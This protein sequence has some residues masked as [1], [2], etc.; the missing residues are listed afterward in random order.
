MNYRILNWVVASSPP[1]VAEEVK[2]SCRQSSGVDP[3]AAV[4]S[5]YQRIGPDFDRQRSTPWAFVVE[6][7]EE[8]A[9]KDAASADLLVAGCGHGRHV[10]VAMKLGYEVTGID[11]NQRM[12]SAAEQ[13]CLYVSGPTPRLL[14]A[15]VCD[16]PFQD[17]SFDA[18]ICIAVLHHLPFDL[19]RTAMVELVRVLRGGGEM[20]VSCWDP[21]APSVAKGEPDAED[22]DVRWVPW[23]LPDGERIMRYYHLPS[24]ERRMQDWSTLSGIEELSVGLLDQNQVMTFR[25]E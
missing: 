8:H 19:C 1:T 4:D 15:D 16:I 11:A 21:S 24:L 9:G 13:A 14:V 22:D 18:V 23:S 12:I 25:A 17:A 20:L 3:R 2:S 10:R 5:A 6:W 7:L